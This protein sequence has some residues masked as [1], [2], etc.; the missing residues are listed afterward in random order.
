[1]DEDA[2]H[3]NENEDVQELGQEMQTWETEKRPGKRPHNQSR[4]TKNTDDELIE[5]L[6]KKALHENQRAISENDEDRMFLLSLVTELHKVP[7]DR[8]LKLKQ[9][10]IGTICQAQQMHQQWPQH[11]QHQTP[12]SCQ[13]SQSSPVFHYA[14][15]PAAHVGYHNFLHNIPQSS[16]TN[17]QS[18]PMSTPA[19]SP[20]MS[21]VSSHVRDY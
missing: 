10:I 12:P 4:K 13:P 2:N 9:D 21:D 5:L 17:L 18:T 7:A 20:A 11:L 8:K 6:K 3:D 19:P 16:N 15:Q 1:M 14:Q